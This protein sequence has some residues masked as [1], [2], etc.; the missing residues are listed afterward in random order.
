MPVGRQAARLLAVRHDP[1]TRRTLRLGSVVVI[2]FQIV[3]RLSQQNGVVIE[4]THP[5]IALEAQQA[6]NLSGRVVVVDL[7]SMACLAWAT[8][9][10][11]PPILSLQQGVVSLDGDTVPFEVVA[12]IAIRI[13]RPVL[14]QSGIAIVL[15]AQAVCFR[16]P[17]ASILD[18]LFRKPSASSQ[19][20]GGHIKGHFG[21][22]AFIVPFAEAPS[23]IGTS[24]TLDGTGTLGHIGSSAVGVGRGRGRSH[25]ARPLNYRAPVDAHAQ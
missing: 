21:T 9:N 10:S 7:E 22:E 18:T 4:L 8:A 15:G 19:I 1:R 6:T 20:I 17:S 2:A 23:N 5:D 16:P 12:E 3:G 14:D 11:A 24:T 13:C 25:V